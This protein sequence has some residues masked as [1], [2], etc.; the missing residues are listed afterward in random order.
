MA[1]DKKD[2]LQAASVIAAARVQGQGAILA[3]LSNQERKATKIDGADKLLK[4]AILD[5]LSA[6]HELESRASKTEYKP[7]HNL[8]K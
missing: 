7:W 2:V 8:E 4:D 5:V 6:L 1:I 3:T